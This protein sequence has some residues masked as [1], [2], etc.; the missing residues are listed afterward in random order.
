MI[1]RN[2]MQTV[3]LSSKVRNFL[4]SWV[5]RVNFAFDGQLITHS[6]ISGLYNSVTAENP[7]LEHIERLL[8]GWCSTRVYVNGNEVNLTS[9]ARAKVAHLLENYEKTNEFA[10][11]ML[12]GKL[13]L[14]N[15]GKIALI[16]VL[17]NYLNLN[18]DTWLRSRHMTS[19]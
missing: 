14:M 9:V 6:C 17:L 15:N 2:M 11:A 5:Q 18:T 4:A 16:C 19:K 7:D 1:T 10:I 13:H 8:K 12:A 3:R